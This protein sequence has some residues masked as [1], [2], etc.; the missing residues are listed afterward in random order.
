[1]PSYNLTEDTFASTFVFDDFSLFNE[2]NIERSRRPRK[3]SFRPRKHKK[4]PRGSS[5]YDERR[6][7]E[8]PR[9][10]TRLGWREPHMRRRR[11]SHSRDG[12]AQGGRLFCCAICGYRDDGRPACPTDRPQCTWTEGGKRH[13]ILTDEAGAYWWQRDGFMRQARH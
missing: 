10:P 3:S 13:L 6:I 2:P 5:L 1:M 12:F 7:V 11:R 4:Q 9:S 8:P